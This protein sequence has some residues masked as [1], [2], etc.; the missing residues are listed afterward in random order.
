MLT[1]HKLQAQARLLLLVGRIAGPTFRAFVVVQHS[2]DSRKYEV[3]KD[4]L[5]NFEL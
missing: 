3:V 5:V 2:L 1:V 4:P